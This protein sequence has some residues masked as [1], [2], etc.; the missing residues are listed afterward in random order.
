MIVRVLASG[1]DV[2]V[3]G[4]ARIEFLGWHSTTDAVRSCRGATS[5]TCRTGSTT[6]SAPGVELSFPN[7]VSLY[8]AAGRPIFYP[9]ARA[10]HADTIPRALARRRRVPFAR[11]RRDHWRPARPP[12]QTPPFMRAAAAA[13]RG[14]CARSLGLHVFRRRFA[15]FVGVDD[16]VLSAPRSLTT[17][18]RPDDRRANRSSRLLHVPAAVRR[19]CATGSE[20]V[21]VPAGSWLAPV[22]LTKDWTTDVAAEDRRVYTITQHADA[23]AELDRRDDRSC[24][25]SH[26]RQRAATAARASGRNL[27]E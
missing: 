18:G 15:E 13:S 14:R 2:R 21:Q 3:S 5:V 9:R 25:L 8:L 16:S 24:A 20:A 27:W 23:L 22:V 6:R 1:I 19:Q 26:A 4:P 12:R 11:R 17:R 7:K 10:S